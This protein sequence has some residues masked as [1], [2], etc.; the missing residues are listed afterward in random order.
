MT[1]GVSILVML[2]LVV[3]LVG[4]GTHLLSKTQYGNARWAGLLPML[5]GLGLAVM[6][7]LRVASSVIIVG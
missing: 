1:P 7:A 5:V 3:F 2:L 6:T 4:M